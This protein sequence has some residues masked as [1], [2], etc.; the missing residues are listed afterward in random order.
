MKK[1]KK[2]F[3]FALVAAMLGTTP[4]L[5][6]CAAES[7]STVQYAQE[8]KRDLVRDFVAR[9]YTEVLGRPA[10]PSGLDAWTRVLKNQTD[11][12]AGVAKG[13]VDSDEFKSKN[14]SDKEYITI[15]YRTFLDRKPDKGGMKAW[16]K[17]LDE[18]MSRMFVFKGFVE[19]PEFTKICED[20][21]IIRG[22]VTLTAP[23][24]QNENMTKFVARCYQIF[25]GRKADPAGLNGWTNAMLS[26]SNNAKQVAHGFVMSPEFQNKGL[27]DEDYVRT[28]Y[29]G[30]FG[31]GADPA[32]LSTWVGILK[33][34]NTRESVF[35]GFADSLE[36]RELAGKFNLDGNWQGTKVDYTRGSDPLSFYTITDGDF[37]YG[38]KQQIYESGHVYIMKQPKNGGPA[39]VIY[40]YTT[41]PGDYGYHLGPTLVCEYKDRIYFVEETS[42]SGPSSLKWVSKDGRSSGV[43]IESLSYEV[44]TPHLTAINNSGFRCGNLLCLSNTMI[45]LDT[46]E[47]TNLPFWGSDHE[48]AFGWVNGAVLYTKVSE[49]APNRAKYQFYRL[50]ADQTQNLLYETTVNFLEEPDTST[51]LPEPAYINGVIYFDNLGMVLKIDPFTG[52]AVRLCD[53]PSLQRETMG[54]PIYTKHSIYRNM[55]DGLHQTSL[56]TGADVL[57]GFPPNTDPQYTQA[58]GPLGEDSCIFTNYN[59][60][61]IYTPGRGFQPVSK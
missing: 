42:R 44:W 48:R 37:V 60:Y 23:M 53:S 24:D 25:L 32:G 54:M 22:N 28:M 20:Y 58:I 39:Q 18:G 10:D 17:V 46:G 6:V 7:E 61:F 50:E 40:T 13:F 35:Y 19:S 5:P 29:K 51:V 14:M 56:E 27:S 33:Y 59:G 55:A 3:I 1:C 34:G 11:N 41:K 12:G 26:G 4:V 31:R 45:N 9:L 15:M 36:F 30:L 52:A 47:M 49:A 21:G 43:L 38:V 2:A 16:Q 8:Q 57:C